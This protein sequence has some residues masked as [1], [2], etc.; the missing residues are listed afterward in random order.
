MIISYV[1]ALEGNVL[2][3][4]ATLRT[5]TIKSGLGKCIGLKKTEPRRKSN[6]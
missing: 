6:C 2:M 5:G 1:Q 4:T 3:A